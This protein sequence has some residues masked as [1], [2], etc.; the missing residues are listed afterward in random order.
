M[1]W[2]SAS[3]YSTARITRK[4][5]TCLARARFLRTRC[6]PTD[7]SRKRDLRGNC[8]WRFASVSDLRQCPSS[9][10]G[11]PSSARSLLTTMSAASLAKVVWANSTGARYQS[12]PRRRVEISAAGVATGSTGQ[13]ARL[14]AGKRNLPP[15]W[16]TPTFPRSSRAES[17]RAER[18]SRWNM[19]QGKRCRNGF[20]ADHCH[21]GRRCALPWRSSKP[22]RRRTG[23]R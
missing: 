23:I 9:L 17:S 22:S 1:C 3:T 5:I 16:T 4:S 10:L 19:S 14:G 11:P 18:S 15:R 2:P 6:P 20:S 12:G 13:K 8:S 21:S 7:S